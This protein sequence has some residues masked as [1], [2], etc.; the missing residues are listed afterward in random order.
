MQETWVWSL[1]W[2]D[3]LEKGKSTHSSILAWRFHGLYSPWGHKSWTRLSDVH[4]YF[5]KLEIELKS[6]IFLVLQF[7]DGSL[8]DFSDSMIMCFNYCDKSHPISIN[9]VQLLSR[10]WLFETQWTA[11]RQASLSITYC[12][13]LLKLKSIESVMPSNHLNLCHLLLLPPSIIPSIRVFSSES[14]LCIIWPKYCSFSFNI[15]PSSGYSGVISISMD[16][17]ISLQSKKLLRV[18]SNITVQKHQ[19]FGVQLSL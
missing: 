10:V 13:N 1:C 16:C 14:T 17:C 9:S 19:L 6:W 7:A 8:L 15:S 3:L 4:I 5:F 12:W 2:E 11:A 18:F